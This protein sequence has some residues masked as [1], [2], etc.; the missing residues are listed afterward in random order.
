MTTIQNHIIITR[1]LHFIVNCPCNYIARSQF[2]SFI[3]FVHERLSS[4]SEQFCTKSSHSFRNQEKFPQPI[5]VKSL[6]LE[7][8]EFIIENLAFARKAKPIP[9]PVAISG[10]VVFL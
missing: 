2:F 7:L 5:A 10:F 6:G 8:I 1:N 3:V 9:S 4:F